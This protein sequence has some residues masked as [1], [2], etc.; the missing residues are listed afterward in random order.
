MTS[1]EHQV[2]QPLDIIPQDSPSVFPDTIQ[3]S[4]DAKAGCH[5]TVRKIGS[6]RGHRFVAEGHDIDE[7]N[8]E[9]ARLFGVLEN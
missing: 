4:A 7:Y 1:S 8:D 6:M 9:I 5:E 2:T 3:Q